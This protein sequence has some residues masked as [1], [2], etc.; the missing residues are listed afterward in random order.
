M[1]YLLGNNKINSQNELLQHA[2]LSQL[3]GPA[4]Q[5]YFDR[6]IQ[7]FWFKKFSE[8]AQYAEKYQECQCH[9]TRRFPDMFQTLYLGVSAFRLARL[10]DDKAREWV[11]LGKKA[12]SKYQTWVKHSE[13][14]W[15][16][17]MQLLEAE[18]HAC[19][20]E[21]EIAK[22][23]FQASIDSARKHRFVHEEGLASE[24]FGMLL[25]ENG[26]VE[27]AKQQ[28]ALARSCYRKWGAFALADRLLKSTAS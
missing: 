17:K 10:E 24:L 12:L 19:E 26:N 2:L 18:L 11:G 14:N 13:W 27:E 15:Q 16:N 7:A 8:A 4:Q 1:F 20:G 22:F 28:Y 3:V 23:K 25:E 21:M 9:Q 5:C 6:L